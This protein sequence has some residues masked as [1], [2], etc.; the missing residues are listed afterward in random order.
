MIS[1]WDD[2]STDF[3]QLCKNNNRYLSIYNLVVSIRDSKYSN[4]IYGWSSVCDLYIVQNEVKHPYDGPRLLVKQLED[5]KLEFRYIDTYI[6]K[7]QWNRVF[8]GI[9]GYRKLEKFFMELHW[10]YPEFIE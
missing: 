7:S 4:H 1:K 9:H 3:E 5:D 8:D 6:T 10:F 2:I